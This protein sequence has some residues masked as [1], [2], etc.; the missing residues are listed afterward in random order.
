MALNSAEKQAE[1]LTTQAFRVLLMLGHHDRKLWE[2]IES[3]QSFGPLVS[4]LILYDARPSLRVRTYKFIHTFNETEMQ[5]ARSHTSED[6]GRDFEAQYRISRWFW[7]HAVQLLQDS[8]TLPSQCT[9]LM[10]LI[11]TL[12]D[13]LLLVRRDIVDL[14]AL[15]ELA[16]DLLLKHETTEVSLWFLKPI[17]L[18]MLINSLQDID[19]ALP[20]DT[21]PRGLALILLKCLQNDEPIAHSPSFRW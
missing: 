11:L 20:F 18:R 2:S 17:D 19:Q 14:R 1:G 12:T 9:E 4:R 21:V 13:N 16:I 5:G 6:S 10:S 8:S 3:S 7:K 15:A